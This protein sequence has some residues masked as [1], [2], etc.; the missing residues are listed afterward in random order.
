MTG[1]RRTHLYR[2]AGLAMRNHGRHGRRGHGCG[3]PWE[4]DPGHP[5]TETG[6]H[7]VEEIWQ[8]WE[9]HGRVGWWHREAQTTGIAFGWHGGRC[10]HEGRPFV[11]TGTEAEGQGGLGRR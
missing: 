10:R 8:E 5:A 4:H 7:H 11:V 9:G 3:R 6:S 1:D 2:S